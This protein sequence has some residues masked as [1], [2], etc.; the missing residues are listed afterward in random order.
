MDAV[1]KNGKPD[2]PWLRLGMGVAA[3]LTFIYGV[4]P[5]LDRITYLQPLIQF[6]DSRGI[7]ATALLYTEIE[8]FSDANSNMQDTM[9]F[10]NPETAY[11]SEENGS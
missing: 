8:E 2:H 6:I 7:N 4:G 9:R 1:M 10:R 11:L 3:I 5:M